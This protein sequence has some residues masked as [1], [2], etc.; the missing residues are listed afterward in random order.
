M[1]DAVGVLND[2]ANL[3]YACVESHGVGAFGPAGMEVHAD[4]LRAHP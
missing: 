3:G 4:N 2:V 1:A